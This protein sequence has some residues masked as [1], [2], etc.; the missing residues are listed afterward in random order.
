MSERNKEHIYIS[1]SPSKEKFAPIGGGGGKKLPPFFG[2]RKKHGEFLRKQ[3]SNSMSS[4]TD[5][6][7]NESQIDGA[8]ITFKSFPGL[9]MAIESL[10]PRQRGK[11]PY[12]ELV[13]VGTMETDDGLVQIATVFVPNGM[14]KYFLS[15][16]DSYIETSEGGKAKNAALIEGIASIQ[17]ATVRELWTDSKEEYPTGLER[18]W[19][20]VWLRKRDGNELG[21]LTSYAREHKMKM[22]TQHLGFGNRIV[23]LLHASIDELGEALALL[24]DISEL[25]LPHDVTS[26]I[27]RESAADQGDWVKDLVARLTPAPDDA[28][29]ACLLD[30]GVDYA[31][32]LLKDSIGKDD[33]YVVE[34]SWN[35]RDV[36]KH[37]TKM[38]GFALYGDLAQALRSSM[39]VVLRHRLESVK[40][41][42]HTHLPDNLNDERYLF[43]ATTARAVD[44]PEIH[45]PKRSRVFSIAC[46]VELLPQRLLKTNDP[47]KPTSWSATIDALA[48]GRA[49]DYSISKFTYL[50]PEKN[51]GGRLFVVNAGNI[52]NFYPN[53]NPLDR[54]D[55]E[56]VEDPGQSW[57][58]ITV[59]AFTNLDDM[60][61]A[62]PGFKGY[63]P[64]ASR[65]ELAPM[66]RTSVIFDPR[67]WPVKPDV[68]AEGGNF[69]VSPDGSTVDTPDNLSLLTTTPIVPGQGLFA[70]A[71][72]TSAAT[73][74]VT[75][76]AAD[77]MAA[78]PKFWPETVRALVIH[79]AEWTP[80]MKERLDIKQTRENRIKLLRRYGMG[81]PNLSR[82][83]YSARDALT[84]IS[85]STIRPFEFLPE[86]GNEGRI[87]EMNLH[88]L[89]WP[90]DALADLHDVEVRMRVTLSYFIEPNPSSRGWSGRYLY[91]SHGL[92]FSV[93]RATESTDVFR[94]RINNAAR[95]KGEKVMNAESD[96]KEWF[97]GVNQQQSAGS[98]HTDI[99][100]GT[101]QDLSMRGVIAVYPVA[102]WWKH[103]KAADRSET[104]VKY[105][106]VISIE[107]PEVDTDLW[108]PVY[109]QIATAIAV[110]I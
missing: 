39:P 24:D 6:G 80:A 11:N 49:I 93:R 89:P 36:E 92:R 70:T 60:S 75:A 84:L 52:R 59:G 2:D 51:M 67:K 64:L 94:K 14:K 106:L 87:R 101:A 109:N 17:R 13:S 15:R 78:Y 63:V 97:F 102:G 79:S 66:S 108:T 45:A 96:S 54:S 9:E 90:T 98:L 91:P 85:E 38:A 33:V 99:W 107:S 19:W 69:A 12:P 58:A 7:Q 46:S 47:G 32:P 76:L 71:G 5:S 29:I 23:T 104:G 40:F 62:I 35:L 41:R 1:G 31:H 100:T 56:P 53:D 83:L 44:M 72:E 20:E 110:E 18:V 34:P 103:N 30:T 26:T 21:R 77:V 61:G 73:S 65:G 95:D 37:G 82:A 22:S 27:A 86:N 25:R 43:G 68:V 57:N 48:A 3:L 105:S 50:D 10:D 55:L 42:H 16:L 4:Q 8:L 88:E 28:P 81:V 74:Q